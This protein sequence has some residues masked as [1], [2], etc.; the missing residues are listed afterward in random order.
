MR[1][2]LSKAERVFLERPEN[3]SRNQVAG[4]DEKNVN[5]GKP[6]SKNS[7][8]GVESYDSKD[9]NRPET[10]DVRAICAGGRFVEAWVRRGVLLGKIGAVLAHP[11]AFGLA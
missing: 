8:F 9:G 1:V 10:I 3:D 6:P 5:A 2:E 7:Y 4:D 11:L